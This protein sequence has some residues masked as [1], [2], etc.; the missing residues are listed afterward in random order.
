MAVSE[1]R[2]AAGFRPK[3]F[4]TL[5]TLPALVILVLLGNWQMDRLE[6]KQDLL[7]RIDAN[8][9]APPVS[10]PASFENS[11]D[12]SSAWEYRRV[13]LQGVFDHQAEQYLYASPKEGGSG[14]MVITPLV[15]HHGEPV[16]VNR[17]WVPIH[18]KDPLARPAGQPEGE[19]VVTGVLRL[20]GMRNSFTPENV[21]AERIWYSRDIA[22]MAANINMTVLPIV[23]DADA[24][25]N[26]GGWPVGG[27]TIVSLPNNHLDYALTWYGLAVVLAVIYLV[28]CWRRG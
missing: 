25:P 22:A 2:R 10:L 28:Y 19:V 26:P 15:R 5:V 24:S 17:G 16:L 11:A 23:L 8:M 18:M 20:Q 14:Y 4:P 1:R 13:T 3:L 21:P 7:A 27:Q 9:S 12:W 6:W